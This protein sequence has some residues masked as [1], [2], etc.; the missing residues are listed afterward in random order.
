MLMGHKH[1]TIDLLGDGRMHRLAQL[2]SPA[3]TKTDAGF[4]ELKSMRKG[5]EDGATKIEYT[6]SFQHTFK[7]M[8]NQVFALKMKATHSSQ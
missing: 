7:V 5:A 4:D 6:G 3:S 2:A 8:A 1:R